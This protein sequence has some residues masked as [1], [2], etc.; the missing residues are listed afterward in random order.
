MPHAYFRD[1]ESRIPEIV[2]IGLA[3]A[4]DIAI[5]YANEKAIA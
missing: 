5:R 1:F 2:A 4:Q 3:K